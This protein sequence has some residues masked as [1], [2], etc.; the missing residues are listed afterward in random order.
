[1]TTAQGTIRAY[2]T[3]LISVYTHVHGATHRQLSEK[4]LG[5]VPGSREAIERA[6]TFCERG[7]REL[8]EHVRQHGGIGAAGHVKEGMTTVSGFL[9][10]VYGQIRTDTPSRML[11]DDETALHFLMTC[12]TMLHTTALA[13]GDTQLAA[14]TR[15]LMHEVPPLILAIG[16]VIPHA[17]ASDLAQEHPDVRANAADEACREANSAWAHAQQNT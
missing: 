4:S 9:A 8:E 13:L 16:E 5:R 6:A 17:V 3:D 11:R 10:G 2:A 15:K 14:L 7:H 1:M 12:T